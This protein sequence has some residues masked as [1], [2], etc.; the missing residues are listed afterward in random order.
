[1]GDRCIFGSRCDLWSDGVVEDAFGG[2]G[3]HEA[4]EAA[5][6]HADADEGADDPDG[7]G[8]PGAPDHDGED[9]GDDA[10]DQEPDCAVAGTKLEELDE[11]DDGLEEEVVGEDQ[12]ED[13]QAVEGMHEKDEAG[14]EVDGADDGL[15]DAAAGGVG[16]VGE[17]EVGDAAEDHGPAEDESDRDAGDGRDEDGEE[18]GEDEEDAEGDG[19]VDGFGEKGAKGG[20]GCAHEG[21]P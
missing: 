3:E 17:D 14:E 4:G 19:P 8:R 9:E 1:M 2:E 16:F 7:A 21:P 5:E 6:D 11:L 15:P 18:S 10:V 20:R 13:E 12:G